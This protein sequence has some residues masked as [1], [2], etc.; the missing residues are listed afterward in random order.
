M[1]IAN[2]II[3]IAIED[4]LE[5]KDSNDEEDLSAWSNAY[6]WLFEDEEVIRE[7]RETGEEVSTSFQSILGQSSL[8]NLSV[9]DARKG[10]RKRCVH[11]WGH[12]VV[13]V[14]IRF[15][16]ENIKKP[17]GDDLLVSAKGIN[18]KKKRRDITTEIAE[19]LIGATKSNKIQW[20][21]NDLD[22]NS[23]TTTYTSGLSSKT[24]EYVYVL[25]KEEKKKEKRG[26][27]RIS[28]LLQVF[29]SS[30]KGNEEVNLK[31]G[32]GKLFK[33]VHDNMPSNKGGI[34]QQILED[35]DT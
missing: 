17:K 20:K 4:L 24:I 31:R 3:E 14:P 15:S 11:E 28:Y 27:K 21:I 6:W 33:V 13:G 34:L 26:G 10:I 25:S 32:I 12:Q 22:L 35:I 8:K 30:D 23:E 1:E 18:L 7:V 9:D 19:A 29:L 5:G 16:L 2:K